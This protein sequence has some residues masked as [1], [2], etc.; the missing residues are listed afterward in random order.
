M[1]ERQQ[2]EKALQESEVRYQLLAENIRDVIW[3]MDL[4]GHFIYVSPSVFQLRGYS[5]EEVM[6][7][8]I[9]E[10]FTS[11]SAFRVLGGIQILLTE[12]KTQEISLR[13]GNCSSPVKMEVRCGP[14]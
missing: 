13:T 3:T 14:R 8:S 6:Q 2:A 5:A 11:D 12:D 4:H 1:L 7:Q 9:Q 10:A